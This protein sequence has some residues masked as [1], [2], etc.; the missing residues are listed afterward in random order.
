MTGDLGAMSEAVAGQ[1]MPRK[2]TPETKVTGLNRD[3]DRRPCSSVVVSAS[4][5]GL[6]PRAGLLNTSEYSRSLTKY[7]KTG[8]PSVFSPAGRPVRSD[9]PKSAYTRARRGDGVAHSSAGSI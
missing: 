6:E 8:M 5:A 2:D 7:S 9:S 1:K 4:R 3:A